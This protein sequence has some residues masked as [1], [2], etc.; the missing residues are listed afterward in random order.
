MT[1][2]YAQVAWLTFAEWLRLNGAARRGRGYSVE[3][4]AA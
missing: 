2:S 1:N 4:T 3:S